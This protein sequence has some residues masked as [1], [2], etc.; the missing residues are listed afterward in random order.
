MG[1]ARKGASSIAVM[2]LVVAFGFVA[3]VMPSWV[4]NS[5]VDAEWEGRVKR[6]QGDLGL[7]GL[8]SDVDFD[9]A[10]V[11]IP[12]KDSVVDF[13]MRTCYSYFWPIDNEIVRIETVIKKDAYTT[14]I[15]DHFHTND[16][17]ASKALA[18]MTGIP[19]SSMKDF[20]DASCSGTGKAVAALV[21]SATL[22]NLLALVLLIVGV[23]C[24]Q[25]RASLPLVARYMV[26]LG[27]VCSAVMSFLMLS[28]LRKAKAS[29]P[30]VSYGLPLYLEFTAFFVA[31]FAGCVIERFECSVKKSANAVDTDKRLQDKMRHQHLISKTNR[32]DI[33]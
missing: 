27:I 31:C 21:L 14:S 9:N 7:W 17:R 10:R 12:G 24:C 6:V 8:C 29:S 18:I 11:L 33:V 5:V 19:S 3:L 13:S 30:H 32:A 15:C 23:C 25:T 20:L 22:L 26:N 1:S 2:V 28:P 16:D 4:T